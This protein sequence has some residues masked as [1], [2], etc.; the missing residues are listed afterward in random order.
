[1]NG[2]GGLTPVMNFVGNSCSTTMNSLETVGN[3]SPCLG[4]VAAGDP[5]TVK[6]HAIANPNPLP[7]NQ[8]PMMDGG[9]RQHA[10]VCPDANQPKCSTVPIYSE[11][12]PTEAV[13]IIT[14]LDHSTTSFNWAQKN[15]AA[16]W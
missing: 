15:F 11:P 9:L 12:S 13:C 14:T 10:T 7:D 8:Y 3:T 1:T 6:L 16:V 2:R 4:V 5:S